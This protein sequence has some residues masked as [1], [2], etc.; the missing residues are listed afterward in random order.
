MGHVEPSHL[1]ELALGHVSG[2]EDADALRHVA[3]CPRC[4]GELAE[5]TRVVAAARGARAGDLPAAPPERVWQRV[6]QEVFR[7]ADRLPHPGEHP[8]GRPAPEGKRGVRSLR[9]VGS[10]AR[11][12]FFALA[13]ATGVLL[14]R[15]LRIRAGRGPGRA[16]GVRAA[17]G[18]RHDPPG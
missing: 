1:V 9:T 11:E 14:V 18:R 4:R 7:R 13:L 12:G 16:P 6:T 3:S 2:A 10:G 5:T 15:W 17:S 8:A